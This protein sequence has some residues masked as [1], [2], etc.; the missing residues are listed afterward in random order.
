MKI[1]TYRCDG[2]CAG[3]PIFDSET[4][5]CPE[6]GIHGTLQEV[7][8]SNDDRSQHWVDAVQPTHNVTVELPDLAGP[9]PIPKPHVDPPPHG[10]VDY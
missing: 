10:E 5:F 6:C 8:R 9:H 1:F 7:N 3:H 2:Q 4:G